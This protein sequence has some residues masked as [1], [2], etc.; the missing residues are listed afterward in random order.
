MLKNLT[1]AGLS[2]ALLLGLGLASPQ[3]AHALITVTVKVGAVTVDTFTDSSTGV[4]SNGIFGVT[5]T[6]GAGTTFT[7]VKISASTNFPGTATLGDLQQTSV[8]S[9]GSTGPA[10][11]TVDVVS[12]GPGFTGPGSAGSP[13]LIFSGLSSSDRNTPLTSFTSI[14]TNV[15]TTTVGPISGSGTFVTSAN[16][17]FVRGATYGLESI[18]DVSPGSITFNVNGT[19]QVTALPEPTPSPWPSWPFP[20]WHSAS[21]AVSVVAPER[22]PPGIC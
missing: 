13:M 22:C 2:F 14:A 5:Y 15:G 11:L 6:D 10:H 9:D 7:Q 3:R 18:L 19:T 1:R 12:S 17:S 21:G 16:G 8:T 4:A 20:R